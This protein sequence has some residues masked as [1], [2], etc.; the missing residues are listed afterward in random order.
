VRRAI[1]WSDEF[2]GGPTE[3]RPECW[4]RAGASLERWR[5]LT[6][7]TIPWPD[8]A[9][10]PPGRRS[11]VYIDRYIAAS[12]FVRTYVRTYRYI[13]TYT[14]IHMHRLIHRRLPE[15]QDWVPE[16]PPPPPPSPIPPQTPSPPPPPQLSSP[17]PSPHS[18]CFNLSLPIPA[19]HS[20]PRPA[21]PG[22]SSLGRGAGMP[23]RDTRR[24]AER[25]DGPTAG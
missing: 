17:T 25:P 9:A 11:G 14:G 1:Q 6:G 19:R 12:I 20:P 18:D 8:G 4:R 15:L 2:L 22:W 3:P 23:A 7:G 13:D 10:G 16:A 5:R 21:P 24:C